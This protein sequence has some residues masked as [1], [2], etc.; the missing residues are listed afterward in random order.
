[1]AIP[2]V[3]N[4]DTGLVVRSIINDLVNYANNNLSPSGSFL[5]YQTI[6]AN[7][8]IPS[9]YNGFLAGPI[10]NNAEIN[11]EPTANLII[12]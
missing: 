1:M 2:L 6:T 8:T 12:I 9:G 7:F 5:N 11:I 4:K 3:K 10:N